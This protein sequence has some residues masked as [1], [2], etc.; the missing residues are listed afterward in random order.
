MSAGQVVGVILTKCRWIEHEG[1]E[2]VSIV[3]SE[4]GSITRADLAMTEPVGRCLKLDRNDRP[5]RL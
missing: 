2:W 4:I 3:S 5:S 1:K